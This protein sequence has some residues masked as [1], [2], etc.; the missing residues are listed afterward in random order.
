[1]KVLK[2]IAG[3]ILVL[4]GGILLLGTI[5]TIPQ[6]IS[7]F[8]LLSG[9]QNAPGDSTYQ[10]AFAAGSVI[11]FCLLIVV[12]VLCLKYGIKLLKRKPVVMD[13]RAEEY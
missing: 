6:F 9:E 7:D 8:S 11:G 5:A 1:M 4:T 2:I 12:A 3:S 10:I 13:E